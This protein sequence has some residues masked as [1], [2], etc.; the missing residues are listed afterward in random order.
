MLKLAPLILRN[1]L[2]SKRRSILT[3]A[4]TAVSMAILALLVALYQGL[5]YMNDVSDAG[6]LRLITRHKVSLTQ[7]L[8]ASHMAKIR[9]VP[10]VEEGKVSA[11]SW[12]Q[13]KYKDNRVSEQFA[14]L[15][16]DADHIFDIF[17]DFTMPPEQLAAFKKKRTA[18]AVAEVIAQRLN[19]KLGDRITIVGDIYP[20]TLELTVEAIFK[21]P[22]NA[23]QVFFHQ[24]YL[25]E[26]LPK[27]MADRDMVGTY[28]SRASNVNDMPR[29]ARAIDA[30]FENSPYPT[31]TESEKEF[32]RTFLA[33]LGNLKLYLGAICAAV[34]F[35]ILLVSANA[36][37]MSVRERTR[38]TAIM[39][40]L[41]YTPGEILGCI[42]G[43]SV[44]ISVVGGVVGL[45][46][47]EMLVKVLSAVTQGLINLPGVQWVAVAIVLGIALLVGL[48]AALV[49]ALVTVR[50]NVVD[51]LRFTG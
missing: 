20:V 24:E 28:V 34:T 32:T 29:I 11:Y 43:E 16:V 6:A 27:D 7:P 23:E 13:G 44:V 41:G 9:S 35:T 15:A 47:G 40:T 1:V 5:F 30:Q 17:S 46:L 45:G 26:L 39:R 8:P 19:I 42:L 50:K 33:F 10:G 48:V 12:F 51:S 4:S 37:S 14:R 22:A 49:P 31:R 38:E 21:H 2:R 25:Q 18:C 36:I 3:L